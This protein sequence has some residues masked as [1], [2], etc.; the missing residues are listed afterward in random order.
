MYTVKDVTGGKGPLL[1]AP[2]ANVKLRYY[3]GRVFAFGQDKYK[4]RTEYD[5]YDERNRIVNVNLS[6][7]EDALTEPLLSIEILAMNAL[8]REDINTF[9]IPTLNHRKVVAAT[10]VVGVRETIEGY[11]TLGEEGK[12]VEYE[13]PI[14]GEYYTTARVV[15]FPFDDRTTKMSW[16]AFRHLSEIFDRVLMVYLNAKDDDVHVCEFGFSH[17]EQ[18]IPLV[19]QFG[20]GILFLD[21]NPTTENGRYAGMGIDKALDDSLIQNMVG[22]S[23]YI[24]A[25]CPEQCRNGCRSCSPER[26]FL[27][28]FVKMN[29]MSNNRDTLL[30][31]QGVL[32][33][34]QNQSGR[35]NRPTRRRPKPRS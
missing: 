6:N 23:R 19:N 7:G 20:P 18:N 27:N 35:Q 13:Q 32:N 34:L 1:V 31:K 17:Q 28:K 21:R 24:L 25:N 5:A 2:K 26:L 16:T 3:R 10:V 14:Q 22:F 15:F 30:N 11:R 8:N 33:L 12:F 4:V 9:T 29:P